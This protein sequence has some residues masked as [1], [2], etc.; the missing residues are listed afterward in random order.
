MRCTEIFK[1]YRTCN[2]SRIISGNGWGRN[3]GR[4]ITFRRQI[5]ILT[6]TIEAETLQEARKQLPTG[7]RVVSEK[8]L[9]DGSPGKIQGTGDTKESALANAR[10]KLPEDAKIL[11]EK[12]IVTPG[13]RVVVNRASDEETL[14]SE[15]QEQGLVVRTVKLEEAG[16]K[17]FLGVGKTLSQYEA[18]PDRFH[19]HAVLSR[20]RKRTSR[21]CH[22][23][24]FGT[25]IERAGKHGRQRPFIFQGEVFFGSS[26]SAGTAS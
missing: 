26:A 18:D 6:L 19:I 7:V 10:T 15:L 20:L 24:G 13:D 5:S 9:S 25:Q 8:I 1:T 16:K 4:K 12:E 2:R 17:G 22:R 21:R 23:S 3:N 14:R 11:E